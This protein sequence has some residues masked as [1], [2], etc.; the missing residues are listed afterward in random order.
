MH[1]GHC[2]RMC[3]SCHSSAVLTAS[4]SI[5]FSI[6]FS[7]G[8]SIGFSIA[9]PPAPHR[10]LDLPPHVEARGPVVV[11]CSGEGRVNVCHKVPA[12]EH[13]GHHA[14]PFQADELRCGWAIGHGRCFHHTIIIL[15]LLL[16]LLLPLLPWSS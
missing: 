11:R 2:G 1:A 4:T 16:L 15:A 9:S 13:A 14:A 12:V 8:F 5:A 10:V 3:R 6:A 7:I